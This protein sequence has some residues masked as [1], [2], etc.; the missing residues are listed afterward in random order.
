MIA[1]LWRALFGGCEHKWAEKNRY[2]IYMASDNERMANVLIEL[3]CEKCGDMKSRRL[4]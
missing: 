2:G 1:R 4:K 3:Q